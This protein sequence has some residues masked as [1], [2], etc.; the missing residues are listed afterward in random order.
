IGYRKG[1]GALLSLLEL[2]RVKEEKKE[3]KKKEEREKE[4]VR[5]VPPQEIVQPQKK[6]FLQG[7]KRL[8]KRKSSS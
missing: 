2:T 6:T 1:D 7:I 5:E 8:F 4:V 3:K